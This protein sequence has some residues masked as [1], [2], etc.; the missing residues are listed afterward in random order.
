[1]RGTDDLPPRRGRLD[2]YI[3]EKVL[4][5]EDNYYDNQDS[6]KELACGAKTFPDA[7]SSGIR[8]RHGRWYLYRTG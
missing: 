1:M 2:L 7:C 6:C 4:E 8:S 3:P 5:D